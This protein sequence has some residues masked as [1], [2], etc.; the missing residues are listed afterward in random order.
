[1]FADEEHGF[2]RECDD[3]RAQQP[4]FAVADH[5]NSIVAVDCYS[6]KNATRGGEWLSEDC[7]FVRNVVRNRQQ[8]YARQLEKLGVRAITSVNAEDGSCSAMS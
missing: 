7:M 6:F 2:A 3:L 4:E 5:G 8:I 1:V